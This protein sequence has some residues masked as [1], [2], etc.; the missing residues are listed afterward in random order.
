MITAENDRLGPAFLDFLN[1][2]AVVHGTRGDAFIQDHF[3]PGVFF[4]KCFG[5]LGQALAVVALVV[6]NGN[7]FQ[8]EDVQ[9]KVHFQAGLG[10]IGSDGA[11]KVGV[12]AA[13]G[14][15][16]VGG[17]WRHD[18]NVGVFVNA[19]RGLGGT[20]ADVAQHHMDAFGNQL[21]GRVGGHFRFAHIVF[22][23]QFH[24]FA[25]NAALGVDIF[26]HQFGSLDG[27]D[28]IGGKVSTV[29]SRQHPV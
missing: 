27:R 12:V 26:D 17:R 29:R 1:D 2:G 8:L 11:E 19:Q 25:Q 16:G 20:G 9:G 21:G 4:Q 10:I 24:L 5:E 18:R 6:Q 22:H 23:Q 28:T 15:R 3:G 14:Q 13:L 7:F